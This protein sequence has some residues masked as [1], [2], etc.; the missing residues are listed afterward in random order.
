VVK[1]ISVK[2]SDELHEALEKLAEKTKKTKAD[3]I[4]DALTMYLG[5]GAVTDKQIKDVK[6]RE[7]VAIYSGKCY[8]CNKEIRPGDRIVFIKI[9]YEDNTARSYTYC[10]DCW[11][12]LSDKTIVQLELKKRKLERTLRALNN[13]INKLIKVYEEL[14]SLEEVNSKLKKTLSELSLF[15]ERV[16]SESESDIKNDLKKFIS[17]LEDL[18]LNLSEFI[19][20]V[21]VKK[22]L[23]SMRVRRK[24]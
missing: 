22:E 2:L 23:V 16:Y 15:I 18:N 11:Y 10:L 24:T 12:E 13:E 3:I 6:Q 7:I 17:E 19:R 21:K 8:R 20:Q 1:E 14:E 4:R 5:M 9:M